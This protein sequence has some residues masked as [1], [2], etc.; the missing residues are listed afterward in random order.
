MDVKKVKNVSKP[1]LD[2]LRGDNLIE[3]IDFYADTC[4]PSFARIPRSHRGRIDRGDLF[5]ILPIVSGIGAI[6]KVSKRDIGKWENQR[7]NGESGFTV[8]LVSF[9]RR[10]LDDELFDS[11]DLS[12]SH[13]LFS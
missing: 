2:V 13:V 6:S 4:H 7:S 5:P 3:T 12:W 10:L 11:T 9:C 8:E 1:P